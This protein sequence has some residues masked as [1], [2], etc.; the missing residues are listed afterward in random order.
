MRT[1]CLTNIFFQFLLSN[2]D[3]ADVVT[4]VST[5]VDVSGLN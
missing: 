1:I 5:L 4:V 3:L 2:R